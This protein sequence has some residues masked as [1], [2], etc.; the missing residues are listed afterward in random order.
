MKQQAVAGFCLA[1]FFVTSVFCSIYLEKFDFGPFLVSKY[2]YQLKNSS[3]ACIK[4]MS[5]KNLNDL[6]PRVKFVLQQSAPGLVWLGVCVCNVI[7]KRGQEEVM[8]PASDTERVDKAKAIL[9]NSLEQFVMLFASQ[10]CL[11]TYLTG[12]QALNIIPSLNLLYIVGRIFFFLGYP[13]KRSFGFLLGFEP[14]LLS[15]GYVGY[16]WFQAFRLV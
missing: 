15:M 8:L 12:K 10:L 14:I 4:T 5:P 2:Q 13:K 3:S 16:R 11:V 1:T 7:I 9:T 6:G